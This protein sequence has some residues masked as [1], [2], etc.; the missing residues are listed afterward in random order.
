MRILVTDSDTR[1][2]L[3]AVRALGREGHEVITAGDRHPSLASV[4]RYCHGFEGYPNPGSIRM[5]SWTR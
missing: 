5:L 2:A 1:S 4:S 3:A